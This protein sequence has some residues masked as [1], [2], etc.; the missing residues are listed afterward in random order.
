MAAL[1]PLVF[2]QSVPRVVEEEV[3]R[4]ARGRAPIPNPCLVERVV[5]DLLRR[6]ELVEKGPAQVEIILIITLLGV[7]L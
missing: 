6:Q 7:S 2:S 5:R 1:H 3:P 4:N